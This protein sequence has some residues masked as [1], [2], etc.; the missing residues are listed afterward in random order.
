MLTDVIETLKM[1]RKSSKSSKTNE[2]KITVPSSFECLR[3]VRDFVKKNIPKD[4]FDKSV[5]EQIVLSVDEACSNIIEHSYEMDDSKEFFLTMKCN[6]KKVQF[7][8]EDNGTGMNVS[9]AVKPDIKKYVKDRKEGGLGKHIIKTVMDNVRY[10][11][12][13]N[14]N[15][16]SLTKYYDKSTV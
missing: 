3:I 2:E 5:V 12:R 13:G 10:K 15:I 9:Q 11:K 16:L 7:V 4:K 6:D 14:R 1:Q 8:I